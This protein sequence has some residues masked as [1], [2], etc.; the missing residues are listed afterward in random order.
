MRH[1]VS[2]GDSGEPTRKRRRL[3]PLILLALAI[4]LFAGL[5]AAAGFLFSSG[6]RKSALAPTP[7][8]THHSRVAAT[9]TAKATVKPTATPT[10]APTAT[11]TTPSATATP[12]PTT[13]PS[14]VYPSVAGV[15][16]GRVTN[17]NNGQA[18]TMTVSLQQSQST[19][20]GNVTIYALYQGV[21]QLR[22]VMS[23]QKTIS[24]LSCGQM[25]LPRF[26]SPVLC[27]L[28]AV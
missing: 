16:S 18:A 23:P 14:P 27:T 13:P 17:T 24:N 22:V 19:I 6:G 3:L 4:L 1:P 20:S 12:V 9:P 5:A 10:T 8:A 11:P 7:V 28:V 26:T 25:A 21:G 15:H 2:T